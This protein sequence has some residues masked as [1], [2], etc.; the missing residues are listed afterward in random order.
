MKCG[1]NSNCKTCINREKKNSRKYRNVIPDILERRN[2]AS[3]IAKPIFNPLFLT[4]PPRSISGD[5]GCWEDSLYMKEEYIK[6]RQLP[7]RLKYAEF[8]GI[9]EKEIENL[10][11]LKEKGDYFN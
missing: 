1:Y 8:G 9:S 5:N 10:K 7:P 11:D 6:P 2:E 4:A 3:A